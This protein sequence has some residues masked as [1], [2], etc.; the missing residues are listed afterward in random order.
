MRFSLQL[1][2][3]VPNSLRVIILPATEPPLSLGG[4]RSTS[5]FRSLFGGSE[6]GPGTLVGAPL[7]AVCLT[8][9]RITCVRDGAGVTTGPGGLPFFRNT[10]LP[11]KPRKSQITSKRSAGAITSLS[12][13]AGLFGRSPPSA[14]MMYIGTPLMFRFRILALQPFSTRNRYTAGST[15]RS[16]QILPLTSITSPKYSPIHGPPLS[17]SSTG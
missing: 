5:A 17:G 15:T 6:P 1:G 16:G 9:I 12:A 4:P 14:P 13:G 11:A 8:R 10:V 2:V 7:E 3:S